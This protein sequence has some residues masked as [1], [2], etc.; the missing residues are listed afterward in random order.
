MTITSIQELNLHDSVLLG[1]VIIGDKVIIELD[2]IDDY[3]SMHCSNRKLCF[4]DCSSISL[5]MNFAYATP[6]SILKGEETMHEG[7][8]KICIE[9]NTTG[10]TIEVIA[11]SV[12]FI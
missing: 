3:E 6:N 12:E 1:V 9:M 4:R 11:A 7:L 2:Y 8:R 10:D 5:H